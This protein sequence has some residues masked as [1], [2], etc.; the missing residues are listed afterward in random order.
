MNDK[1]Y[2]S[3]RE[4]GLIFKDQQNVPLT[5]FHLNVQ[6]VRNKI[7]ELDIFLGSFDFMYDIIMLS[8]TWYKPNDEVD[9]LENY[10]HFNLSRNVKQGGGVCMH[11]KKV[12]SVP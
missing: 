3:P 1:A 10:E 2:L 8:E 5:L 11:I 12:T 7:E 4:V 6:S 9:I